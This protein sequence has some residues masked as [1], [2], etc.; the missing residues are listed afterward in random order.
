ML[1][2]GWATLRTAA[3][4]AAGATL[5]LFLT[6]G[7]ASAGPGGISCNYGGP[8]S[9]QSCGSVLSNFLGNMISE[10]AG[11][12]V[13]EAISDAVKAAFGSGGSGQPL[14]FAGEPVKDAPATRA[15]NA[16]AYGEDGLAYNSAPM[17]NWVAWGDL[18][19][20]H[21]TGPNSNN[22]S[23][24]QA[25]ALFGLG[26]QPGGNVT[27]GVFG[28]IETAD[29]MAT[30][31]PGTLKSTG[32]TIGTYAGW[33][34]LP[35]WRLDGAVAW[36]A[37]DMQTV[38]IGTGNFD[39]H[40]WLVT[41][42]LTGEFHHGGLVL[43]PS[44]RIAAAFEHHDAYTDSNALSTPAENSTVG[45]ASVGGKIS[46]PM[47]T[48]MG[49]FAPFVGLYGD[50]RFSNNKNM[51]QPETHAVTGL[52]GRVA[53]GASLKLPT[54]AKLTLDMSFAG[55][56]SGEYGVWSAHGQVAIPF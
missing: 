28:G 47:M 2:V 48:Q 12:S 11:T 39:G 42:G 45:I 22:F 16:L 18:R 17:A 32:Y 38:V 20:T 51:L 27:F 46:Y 9:T 5:A 15:I 29:Y 30:V 10:T 31:I 53:G 43:E 21:W 4:S 36:S 19:G 3:V 37:L 13:G 1:T 52:T 7:A 55:L 41:G 24:D 50:Y 40:R 54:G 26:Y 35:N 34:F 25:N 23:G 8:S 33:Q 49:V 44:A 6:V 14:G 56:G